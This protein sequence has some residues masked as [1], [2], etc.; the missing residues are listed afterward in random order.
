M[1]VYLY[2]VVNTQDPSQEG[3]IIEIEHGIHDTILVHPETGEPLK[4]VYTV[5][6]IASRYTPNHTKKM[7]TNENLNKMGFTKYERDK[8]TGKYH[9]TA[10]KEGPTVF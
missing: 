1:P 3:P 5:P 6:M 10:G 4:R 8:V 9:R 7:L 2:Q